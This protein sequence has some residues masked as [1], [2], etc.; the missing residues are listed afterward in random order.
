MCKQ[1]LSGFDT[2]NPFSRQHPRCFG[3]LKTFDTSWAINCANCIKACVYFAFG[4]LLSLNA[5]RDINLALGKS[6]PLTDFGGAEMSS[7]YRDLIR[8]LSLVFAAPRY[9]FIKLLHL[10]LICRYFD[11]RSH[12]IGSEMDSQNSVKIK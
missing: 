10:P 9:G 11:V 2:S 5:V 1:L 3:E 4:M 6:P 8:R 12:F 7:E